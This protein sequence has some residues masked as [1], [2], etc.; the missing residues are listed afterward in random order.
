MVFLSLLNDGNCSQKLTGKKSLQ[1]TPPYWQ[2]VEI[3]MIKV[4]SI[5]YRDPAD[6]G[7]FSADKY[8]CAQVEYSDYN[9]DHTCVITQ[10][11]SNYRGGRN[12]WS[13][14]VP[15]L[16]SNINLQHT[17][18][19]LPTK[20]CRSMGHS[21]CEAQELEEGTRSHSTGMAPELPGITLGS[22]P[23]L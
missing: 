7:L 6:S 12:S 15:D 2:A 23:E 8:H 14:V 17:V 1:T 19:G 9:N 13:R 21:K 16:P 22:A 3:P 18:Q 10:N 11:M 4:C 5:L 20:L